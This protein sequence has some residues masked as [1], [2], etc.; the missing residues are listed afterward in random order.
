MLNEKFRELFYFGMGSATLA[1]DVASDFVD[2]MIRAGKAQQEQRESLLQEMTDRAKASQAEMEKLIREKIEFIAR[3]LEL[4]PARDLKALESRLQ[5]V[6]A[7]L[8]AMKQ[9]KS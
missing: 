3:E 4:V 7:E 6:E 9:E 8:Q 1:K 5:A 2:E